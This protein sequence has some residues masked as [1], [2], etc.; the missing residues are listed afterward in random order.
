MLFPLNVFFSQETF[1][2]AMKYVLSRFLFCFKSCGM[3]GS[4]LKHSA[5]VW[6]EVY[7]KLDDF[8]FPSNLELK[9]MK[10]MVITVL[11]V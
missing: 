11:F 5:H 1:E 8:F 2:D 9:E 4:K 6:S 3:E 7:L 10:E